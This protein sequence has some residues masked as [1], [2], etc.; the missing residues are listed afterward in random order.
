MRFTVSD[1][2]I[3]MTSAQ[4]ALLFEPFVQADSS[5]TRRFGG[6][7]LGLTIS[8]RLAEM[9][10]GTITVESQ[11]GVGSTFTATVETGALDGV[12]WTEPGG[13]LNPATPES[14][15][16]RPPTKSLSCSIL[17][18]EDSPD[19]Q[20]LISFHL[21]RAGARVVVAENGESA[22]QLAMEAEAGGDC[23]DVVIMDMQMPIMDGYAATRLLRRQGYRGPIVALTANAMA[24]DRERCLGAG[25]DDYATKPIDR[26]KLVSLIARLVGTKSSSPKG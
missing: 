8:R 3:G 2:G 16:W 15:A 26:S 6:T 9:L 21:S 10:G 12:E 23:F 4:I 24:G 25:C 22:V 17:L 5:T 7:G 18:A 14:A 19:N 11:F 20:R 1:T 13:L